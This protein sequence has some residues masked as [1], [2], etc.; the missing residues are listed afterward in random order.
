MA[1]GIIS[2]M[3][4]HSVSAQNGNGVHSKSTHREPLKLSGALDRFTWED[5]TPVIGRE[6]PNLNVVDDLL[7]ASNADELLRELAIT[8]KSHETTTAR[9]NN[10]CFFQSHSAVLSSSV[11]RTTSQ[12]NY[13]SN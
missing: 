12:M 5:A 3:P 2:D 6:F 4:N 13:R 8:S 1:P 10:N 9:L 7:N 11:P